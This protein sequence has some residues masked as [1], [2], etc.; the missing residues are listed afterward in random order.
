MWPGNRIDTDLEHAINDVN[1][2]R[3]W[4]KH[5]SCIA[6]FACIITSESRTEQR[7]NL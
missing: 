3:N 6:E 2:Q 4:N 1:V 5:A 7:A